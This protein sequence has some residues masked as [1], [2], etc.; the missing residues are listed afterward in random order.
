MPLAGYTVDFA[1]HRAR[2]VIEIDGP[3][4][5]Q[6][7]AAARDAARDREI[8]ARGWRVLRIPAETAQD[9][10]ALWALVLHQL[11]AGRGQ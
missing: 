6:D 9:A 5:L 2:L 1:I 3:V 11:E 8:E 10:D 4:H 7:G